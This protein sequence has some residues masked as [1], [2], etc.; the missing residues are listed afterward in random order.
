MFI[1]LRGSNIIFFVSLSKPMRRFKL[2]VCNTQQYQFR[3]HTFNALAAYMFC[4]LFSPSSIPG[5]LQVINIM[6][7]KYCR[8]LNYVWPFIYTSSIQSKFKLIYSQNCFIRISPHSSKQMTVE[9]SCLSACINKTISEG[10]DP[11]ELHLTHIY[12]NTFQ[13]VYFCCLHNVHLLCEYWYINILQMMIMKNH[14]G[15]LR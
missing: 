6:K 14:L 12:N 5:K 9:S 11:F 13:W 8:V 10:C 15:K 7:M 4:I 3:I 1:H 2:I